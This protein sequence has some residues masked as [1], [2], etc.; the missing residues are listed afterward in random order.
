M[1]IPGGHS[2]LALQNT[3]MTVATCRDG[4]STCAQDYDP[5]MDLIRQLGG[6]ST[7]PPG[8]GEATMT[9]SHRAILRREVLKRFYCPLSTSILLSV[10]ADQCL[11]IL[12]AIRKLLP[13]G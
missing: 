7:S 9:R 5:K 4:I 2:C 13:N 8:C 3:L 6:Y 11:Y 12:F 10:S 1:E